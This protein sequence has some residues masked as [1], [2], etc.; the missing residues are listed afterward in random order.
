MDQASAEAE[1]EL[2]RVHMPRP[3]MLL[4]VLLAVPTWL[5]HQRQHQVAVGDVG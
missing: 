5:D 3:Q 1:E 2:G 4:L